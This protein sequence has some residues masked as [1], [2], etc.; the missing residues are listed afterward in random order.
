MNGNTALPQDKKD[1]KQPGLLR[2]LLFGVIVWVLAFYGIGWFI[3]RSKLPS[4]VSEI[5]K[6]SIAALAL[7]ALAF[8]T[9][10]KIRGLAVLLALF[11]IVMRVAHDL[12]FPHLLPAAGTGFA[13]QLTI[14]LLSWIPSALFGIGTI[15][16]ALALPFYVA[17]EFLLAHRGVFGLTRSEAIWSLVILTFGMQYPYVIVENGDYTISKPKGMINKIGGPGEVIVRP[18][19]AVALERMGKITQIVG[20]GKWHTK[21]FEFPK[22]VV[23]L[24]PRWLTFEA[25]D[26]LTLDGVPM[27]VSGGVGAQIEPASETLK[28]KAE[29]EARGETFEWAWTG[30][31]NRAQEVI[32]GDFPVYRDSIFRAVYLPAGP[33]WEGTLGGAA[34][35]L[36]RK[37]VRQHKLS[38]LY[39]DPTSRQREVEQQ[40]GVKL[41]IVANSESQAKRRIIVSLEDEVTAGLRGFASQWGIRVTGVSINMLTPPEEVQESVRRQ[42]TTA[43]EQRNIEAL[44]EAEAGALQK[45]EET[46]KASFEG[47]SEALTQAVTAMQR[48]GGPEQAQRF[49]EILHTIAANLAHDN[50]SSLR[51]IEAMEKLTKHPNARVILMP[52]GQDRRTDVTVE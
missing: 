36:V 15:A 8:S 13:G 43:A 27:K 42:Y 14:W 20:P 5:L 4:E 7:F 6:Y 41:P 21:L 50:T 52:P 12:L 44:G 47:M 9:P 24:R 35:A 28:R 39:G 33:N 25:N 22:Q 1:D 31:G 34:L 38:E 40:K 11:W 26:V 19:N 16:F 46:K 23:Q 49:Q 29:I 48:I 2:I 10:Q 32:A 3:A 18:A 17:S 51:Y 45:L 30:E 37:A